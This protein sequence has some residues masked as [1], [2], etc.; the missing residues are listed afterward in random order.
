ME[1]VFSQEQVKYLSIDIQ[2]NKNRF[3]IIRIMGN[4]KKT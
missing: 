4:L 3:P 1:N 2:R